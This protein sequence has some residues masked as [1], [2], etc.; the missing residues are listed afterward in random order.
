MQQA[1]TAT[2]CDAAMIATKNDITGVSIVQSGKDETMQCQ[3]QL[4]PPTCT[5]KHGACAGACESTRASATKSGGLGP[6]RPSNFSEPFGSDTHMPFRSAF[7]RFHPTPSLSSD[8]LV[9]NSVSHSHFPSIPNPKICAI[10]QE[11][12]NSALELPPIAR[13]ATLK[14]IKRMI[15]YSEGKITPTKS[16]P[17]GESQASSDVIDYGLPASFERVQKSWGTMKRIVDTRSA[18]GR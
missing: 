17:K 1:E 3:M 15:F 5:S 10:I 18:G 7:Q 8:P 11:A 14:E 9:V 13:D 12:V 16:S 2:G 6:W 4:S